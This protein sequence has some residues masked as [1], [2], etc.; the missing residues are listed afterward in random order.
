M[1]QIQV[2]QMSWSENHSDYTLGA[3]ELI[4]YHQQYENQSLSYQVFCILDIS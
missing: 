1:R 2:A 3:D 4:D